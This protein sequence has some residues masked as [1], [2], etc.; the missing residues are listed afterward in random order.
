MT[1][2]PLFNSCIRFYDI[3]AET[4]GEAFNAIEVHPLA[5]MISTSGPFFDIIDNEEDEGR[6]ADAY[7]VSVHLVSG[8]IVCVADCE[9]REAADSLAAI[10]EATMKQSPIK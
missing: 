3:Q 7:G 4:Q 10:L 6:V 1:Q 2:Q 8:G 9:T 5:I